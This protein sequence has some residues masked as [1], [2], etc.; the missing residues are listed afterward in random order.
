MEH[1][2]SAGGL[3]LVPAPTARALSTNATRG[4]GAARPLNGGRAAAVD[5][6]RRALSGRWQPDRRRPT[7]A[8]AARLAVGL[9]IEYRDLA[10]AAPGDDPLA[11]RADTPIL[12][13]S[14]KER[15]SPSWRAAE[16]SDDS[17]RGR[18]TQPSRITHRENRFSLQAGNRRFFGMAVLVSH[19]PLRLSSHP[20]R[21]AID[22]RHGSLS[23]FTESNLERGER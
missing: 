3:L 23:G 17:R 9:V 2:P 7:T 16:G 1:C 19:P 5:R 4:L 10:G 11:F 20:T 8:D 12:A 22:W 13:E 6:R 14:W 15:R 18:P 21:P